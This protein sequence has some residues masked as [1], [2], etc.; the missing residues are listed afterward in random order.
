[1]YAREVPLDVGLAA[2]VNESASG[3]QTQGTLLV[4]VTA[5]AAAAAAAAPAPKQLWVETLV[6]RVGCGYI[7]AEGLSLSRQRVLVGSLAPQRRQHVV[8]DAEEGRRRLGGGGGR[9]EGKC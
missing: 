5:A 8:E 9:G 2:A 6:Q 4:S 1:M 7:H 3:D